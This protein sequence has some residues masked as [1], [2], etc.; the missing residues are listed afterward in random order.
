MKKL[1]M[2]TLLMAALCLPAA[3]TAAPLASARLT[4]TGV[5]WQPAA[6]YEAMVLT[7]SGP[8]GVV[9]RREF[10]GGTAP[11]LDL[12]GRDGNPLTDG[13]YRWE[14]SAAPHL[15]A[16]TRGALVAARRAGDD[17]VVSRLQAEG[18]LPR[19]PLVQSGSFSVSGGAIVPSDLVEERKAA[20]TAGTPAVRSKALTPNIAEDQV[21]PDDL[22]VQGSGCVGFDCVNNESFGFDT[23][24]LKENNLR[25]K[26]EDTSVGTFPTNDWQLT[27]NDSRQRRRQQVL[28]RGHHRLQGPVHHHGRRDDQLDLRRQHGPRRLPHLD[29]GARP[30]RQHQQHPGDPPRAEQLRRL[31]RPDLGRRRPTRRT[32]SSAT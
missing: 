22:I 10:K 15:D 13:A 14:L 29:A 27:A 30:P 16:A 23:I 9:L 11:S 28:D 6:S 26:F 31:H 19:S 25:I 3:L 32:S 5:E 18:K 1:W 4:P 2:V 12:F 21:I 20:A 8:D 24:R 17:S 7:V